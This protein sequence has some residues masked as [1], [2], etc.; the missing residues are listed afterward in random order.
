MIRNDFKG[1]VHDANIHLSGL[2]D[3]YLLTYKQVAKI[4]EMSIRSIQRRVRAGVL[5]CVRDERTVRFEV[6]AVREYIDHYVVPR[7]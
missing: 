4:L 3:K 5:A 6:Q 1:I 7:I 2:E